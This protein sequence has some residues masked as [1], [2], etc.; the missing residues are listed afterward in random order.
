MH[1]TLKIILISV[2]IALL[3]ALIIRALIKNKKEKEKPSLGKRRNQLRIMILIAIFSS[4]SVI[5]YQLNFSLPIFPSFLKIHF[6]NLP[7]LIGGF[8][9]GPMSGIGML[10]LR[11]LFGLIT[12]KSAYVGEITDLIIG[13]ASVIPAA[14]IYKKY[15][16]KKGA[17]IS[18]IVSTIVWVVTAVFI[19]YIFVIPAYIKLY[20]NG[21]VETFVQTISVIPGVNENNYMGRYLLFATLPFNL[22]LSITIN[23]ITFLVYKRISPLVHEFTEKEVLEVAEETEEQKNTLE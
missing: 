1:Q 14:I 4:F 21:D 20:F 17:G 16:T 6:S 18:L 7:I 2:S 19:N 12:T 22:L 15:R 10:F 11:F 8:T 13:F 5:A 3:V 23:I 9:L